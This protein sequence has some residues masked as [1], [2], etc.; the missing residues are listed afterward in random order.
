M[1]LS[2]HLKVAFDGAL[3]SALVNAAEDTLEDWSEGAPKSVLWD[4][5]K[6]V[7][8]GSFEVH[9]RLHFKIELPF[10]LHM[11]THLLVYKSAKS[12]S[13]KGEFK[14]SIYVALE[15]APKIFF[16]GALK[17]AQKCEEKDIFDVV[18]LF[19]IFQLFLFMFNLSKIQ[20]INRGSADWK[21]RSQ[22]YDIAWVQ[23]AK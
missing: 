22:N 2:L 15:G 13:V 10:K 20:V 4:L 23:G 7:P 19:L 8:E 6:D 1:H 14:C 18:K 17:V 16:Q 12:N 11:M 21:E 3:D 9:A 5:Y